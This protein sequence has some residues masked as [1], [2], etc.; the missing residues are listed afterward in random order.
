[1][2]KGLIFIWIIY[3]GSCSSFLSAG[4]R[5]GGARAIRPINGGCVVVA[6][7]WGWGVPRSAPLLAAWSEWAF[8]SG[9]R[10]FTAA[11]HVQMQL[12]S[13]SGCYDRQ[14]GGP[15]ADGRAN[16]HAGNVSTGGPAPRNPSEWGCRTCVQHGQ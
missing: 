5:R 16:R 7:R 4:R 2:S 1:M 9:C 6:R 8:C 14:Y 11:R 10:A 13:S 15:A 12:R 3:M